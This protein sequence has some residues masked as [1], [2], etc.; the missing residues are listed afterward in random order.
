MAQDFY[1][2]LGLSKGAST[3]EVRKAFKKLARKYHPDVNPGDKKAE[4][5]FKTI[6][7][8]YEV[9]SNPE[10][11]KKYDTYGSAD[12]EGFP[13][14][15]AAGGRGYG[16]YSYGPQGNYST[17]FDVGDL[18]DIFGDIFGGMGGATAGGGR[19]RRKTYTRQ[20]PFESSGVKGQ[21]LNF[22]LEL[23]FLEAAQGCEKKIRLPNGVAF[24]VRIPA[25]VHEG[26]KIRLAGKGEPGFNGGPAGDLFIVPQIKPHAYFQRN[27][28]NIELELPVSID[29]AVQGA[30]I[31]VPTI[32]GS[33]DLKIPAGIQSGQKMRLK[34]RGIED[35]KTKTPGD[36]IVTIMVKYPTGID[37][38]TQEQIR[39]IL[40][41]IPFNPRDHFK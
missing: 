6:S 4:D 27:G 7:E 23:D 1:A 10:K 9:L 36:Q 14:G 3:D 18:G 21:D 26:G 12:F 5:Q 33:V 32:T 37:E 8:A 35:A 34:G 29:E 2:A 24:N 22:T 13:G 38:K 25:G 19:T 40:K 16:G 20:S 17:Q 11:K 28:F 39:E 30:K 41:G 31:K 15:G